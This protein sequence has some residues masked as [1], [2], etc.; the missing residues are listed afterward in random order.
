[1][2]GLRAPIREP[3]RDLPFSKIRA[4]SRL[5]MSMPDVSPLW[6]GE[7]DVPTPA[8]I[9]DAAKQALDEGKTF[10]ETN[11]GVPALVSEL[12][13]YQT[14]LYRRTI[15][16]ERITVTASGM[17]ALIIAM[18]A[19]VDPGCNVVVV[20]PVWPNCR[21]TVKIMGGEVRDV[22]L[23]AKDGRFALDLDK[24]F[25]ACDAKTRALFVNSPGNPTGWMMPN[26]QQ[27]DVLD[28][29]RKRGI[30]I[31]SDEVYARIVYD[32]SVAPS[33]LEIAEDDDA[34]IA[35]NSFSKAWT[36]TG[37]R[38]GW[39]TAP[40][41][42]SETFEKLNEFNISGPTSFVQRAGIVAV[43]DGEP[44]IASL[45]ERYARARD[46]VTQRL[47]GMRRVRLLRPEAAFYA[48]FAVEGMTDSL[49][50]CRDLLTQARVGLAPGAAFGLGG[51]GH[52]RLCFAATLPKLT[53]ALDRLAPVLDR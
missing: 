39:L 45:T 6:F 32:R 22:A 19:I 1:M 41:A 13:A 30:W 38:L 18:Q 2:S 49:A 9:A 37:W 40:P 29:C 48:F 16:A 36:M 14:R 44:F 25:A 17:N 26:A 34:V 46:L 42:L 28:F 35:V 27:K 11:K 3:I 20:N 31:V 21:E 53:E 4:V 23:D 47:G 33:F 10:Y 12:A 8:F 51:E 50:T 52:I 43:R 15:G 24:L 7:G 5:G